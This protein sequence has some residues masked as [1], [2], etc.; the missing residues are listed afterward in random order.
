M[1]VFFQEQ[2]RE[3]RTDPQM[4]NGNRIKFWLP[5][6]VPKSDRK[7]REKATSHEFCVAPEKAFTGIDVAAKEGIISDLFLP[8]DVLVCFYIH[9]SGVVVLEVFSGLVLLI[10][11]SIF[12]N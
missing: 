2:N 11:L 7:V 9:F 12:W 10:C 8:L 5:D 3:C 4:N 6:E 1:S